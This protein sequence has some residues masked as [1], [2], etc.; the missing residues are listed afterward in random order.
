ML[1]IRWATEVPK[2][3]DFTLIGAHPPAGADLQSVLEQI[4]NYSIFVSATPTLASISRCVTVQCAKNSSKVLN[5]KD[6]PAARI[7]TI[8]SCKSII[9]YS[10]D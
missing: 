6:F 3:E 7:S 5:R 4:T 1:P 8:Q 10:S 2:V 9:F